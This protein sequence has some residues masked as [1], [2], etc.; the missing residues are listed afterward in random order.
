[1]AV[2]TAGTGTGVAATVGITGTT[3]VSGSTRKD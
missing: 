2:A 3:G 1:M